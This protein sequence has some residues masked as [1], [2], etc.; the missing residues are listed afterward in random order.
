MEQ[1]TFDGALK[2]FITSTADAKKYANMC[3]IMAL[4]HFQQHGDVVHIQ[5]F[6]DTMNKADVGKNFLRPVAFVRWCAAHSP[7][8]IKDGKFSKDTAE[9]AV[10]WDVDAAKAITF[11]D[12]S[13]NMEKLT[14]LDAHDVVKMAV[15][16]VTRLENDKKYKLKDQIAKD[17]LTSLKAVIKTVQVPVN[18]DLAIPLPA[19]QGDAPAQQDA[20]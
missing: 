19:N 7:L 15:A 11:W 2:A 3:A 10:K 14:E 17:T 1:I 20:A 13:P 12:F 16:L 18:A 9:N 6:Y 4:E 5:T 8:A